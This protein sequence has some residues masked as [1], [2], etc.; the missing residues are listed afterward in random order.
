MTNGFIHP[1]DSIDDYTHAINIDM[2]DE[3]TRL[4]SF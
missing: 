2:I 3:Y 4:I 1:F